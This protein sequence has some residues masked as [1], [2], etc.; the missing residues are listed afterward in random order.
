MKPTKCIEGGPAY[1]NRPTPREPDNRRR[2][3]LYSSTGWKNKTLMNLRDR[4]ASL[5]KSRRAT[6]F[7][8][9]ITTF[10]G[11]GLLIDR[12]KGSI[13]EWLGI[14]F[15]ILG[16]AVFA[17]AVWPTG[18]VPV[19]SAPNLANRL[20]H[21]LTW[22]GR[23]VKLFPAIGV[24]IVI[25][26]LSFNLLLSATPA[27][28]TEDIIVL[29]AAFV[30]MA[31][32]FVPPRYARERDFVLMFFIALNAILVAPLLVARAYYADF[33]RSVDL[34]SWAALAPETGAVL[35][36]LGV[37]NS[38]HAVPGATAPGL[39]FTPRNLAVQVTIVITTSCSGIYSFGIFA[40]AFAAFVLTEYERPSKRMWVL[41]GLGLLASYAANVL[42]MVVIVLIGYYTDTAATDLQNMLIAHSYAGWLIF[43]GWIALFWSVAFKLMPLERSASTAAPSEG[44]L[45]HAELRCGICSEALTPVIPATRCACGSY[46]HRNCLATAQRC[47]ACGRS[48]RVDGALVVRGT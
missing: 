10:A 26:D 7:I 36:V 32:G 46:Y 42:R 2:A 21:W 3:F 30:L 18:Q 15:L 25:A 1:M 48:F 9:L 39:T 8:A 20:L 33:E 29:L 4:I 19:Q 45:T 24:A 11:V 13:L 34:Y 17:W 23:L 38:V 31:Y 16:G 37:P 47:P 6:T 27:L 12:P 14:P 44:R 43:L 35:S 40:S 41:L 5:S 22:D 28:L